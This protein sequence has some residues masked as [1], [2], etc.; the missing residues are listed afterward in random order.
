MDIFDTHAH[1]LD[2]R[3]D[4][5]R[6]ALIASLRDDGVKLVMEA[7]T[8]LGYLEKLIP[9]VEAHPMIYGAAGLHPEELEGCGLRDLD[10][11]EAALA[12]PGIRAVGEIGLDYYWPENPAREIQREFFDAQLSLAAAHGL[13][14]II[15]DREAHGDTADVLRAHKGQ[16]FGVMHC[17]S[18][19]WETAKECLDL[20]FYIG[21]GGALTF[22]NAKRNVEVASKVPL[23]RLVVETD[24]PY[25]APVPFRGKRNDPAKTRFVIGKLAE[26]RCMDE[27][28][29]AP[30]LFENGKRLFGIP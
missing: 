7:C 26:I 16:A 2:E 10:A 20:G 5:D 11:V 15:H 13:P 3:F 12:H 27:E 24:C 22:K 28:E 18:G 19:S 1:I 6:E 30:V 21:F 9:F 29:L 14:V 4:E 23:D 8:D 17:F 25:M